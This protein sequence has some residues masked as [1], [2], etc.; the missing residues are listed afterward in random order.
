MQ[1]K[2]ST[3]TI[4]R[5]HIIIL[6]KHTRMSTT[7][8]PEKSR[9]VKKNAY[10]ETRRGSC[11]SPAGCWRRSQ[12]KQDTMIYDNTRLWKS[13]GMQA[14]YNKV[15]HRERWF[16]KRYST[17]VSLFCWL[18]LLKLAKNGDSTTADWSSSSHQ[19][20]TDMTATI[21]FMSSNDHAMLI[22]SYLKWK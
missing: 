21:G 4:E 6:W 18:N 13:R 16:M 2:R 5:Q 7:S 19:K 22:P 11:A 8:N 9:M 20:S 3:E 17:L 1:S 12:A 10:R 14:R 15:T